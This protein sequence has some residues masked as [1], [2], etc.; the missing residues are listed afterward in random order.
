M[1]GLWTRPDDL[2]ANRATVEAPCASASFSYFT[3]HLIR[4]PSGLTQPKRFAAPSIASKPSN[5]RGSASR[6]LSAFSPA[7]SIQKSAPSGAAIGARAATKASQL[8]FRSATSIWNRLKLSGSRRVSVPPA[9]TLICT[10]RL[11]VVTAGYLAYA[12]HSRHDDVRH[13]LDSVR[14]DLTRPP[15]SYGGAGLEGPPPASDEWSDHLDVAIVGGGLTG[16]SIA[17]HLAGRPARIAVF[18]AREIAH[19][20]SGRAFGQVVPY[21]K[22]NSAR[23]CRMYGPER[24]ERLVAEIAAGPDLVFGLISA[25][26][27]ACAAARTGLLF[28]ARTPKGQRSLEASAREWQTRGAPVELLDANAAAG[29]TGSKL[30]PAALLDRRGGHL[31]PLAY[32]WGLGRAATG[33]G[34]ALHPW[35]PVDRL[36]RNGQRW[37]LTCGRRTV[38]ADVVVLATN[39]YTSG[40]WPGLAHSFV[41]VRVHA[42]V[43]VPLP[44]DMLARILPGNHPLTDTRRLYSGLRKLGSRLHLTT[45]GPIFGLAGPASL[46]G[47]RARLAELYPWLPP[48]AFSEQWGGWIAV[49]RDQVP[50]VH[51]LAPGLWAG[52]GYSGRGLA[53]ATILGRDLARR[54]QGQPELETVFPLSPLVR[55]PSRTLGRA[56]V[57]S[58]V[59]AYRW[60]DRRDTRA[61]HKDA[62]N[63]QLR[64]RAASS[65]ATPHPS[66]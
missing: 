61:I 50:H 65:T 11:L 47:A 53:A 8:R 13:A 45:D 46:N 31:D 59:A 34:V 33:R 62:L 5:H 4:N 63:R 52:L 20:A 42:S 23:L 57:A 2:A 54:I 25:E 37:Q 35:I 28:G 38:T 49:T 55:L 39:A 51:E 36:A 7:A 48:V 30:Y 18:E 32:T 9:S 66:Q 64:D 44:A 24:G 22:H 27:I 19:G 15:A 17:Y 26:K 10:I 6:P 1:A 3:W 21:L 43:T 29:L 41:P 60:L 14:S 40:L 16:L 56:V 12:S 58:T